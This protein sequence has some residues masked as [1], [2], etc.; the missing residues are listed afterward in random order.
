MHRWLGDPEVTRFLSWGAQ[1]RG[2]SARHLA[3]CIAEQDLL[4]RR[5]YFLAVELRKSGRVIGDAGFQWTRREGHQR[6][7]RFGYFLERPYW[8]DGYGAEAAWLVLALA[9]G[10]LGATVMRASC[11]ARNV[12]S[13]RVMQKCGMQRERGCELLGRRAYRIFSSEWRGD[14]DNSD[15]AAFYV[16]PTVKPQR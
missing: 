16:G 4:E 3:E 1:T 7:G 5:R 2:D 11:D 12:A 9:F 15:A 8:S 6:E 14:P 13:E 10:E